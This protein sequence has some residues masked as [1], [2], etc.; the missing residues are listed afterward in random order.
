ME[1]PPAAGAS[2]GKPPLGPLPNGRAASTAPTPNGKA[3]SAKLAGGH[4][5]A[6][7]HHHHHRHD[8]VG[9]TGTLTPPFATALTTMAR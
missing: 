8:E 6:H 1:A 5:H 2:G 4:T 3:A 9:G 7:A